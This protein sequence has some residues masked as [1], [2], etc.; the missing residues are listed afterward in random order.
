TCREP[1]LV[2]GRGDG[3]ANPHPRGAVT[4]H[5]T[6]D[7]EGTGLPSYEPDIGA[8][9]GRE[10]LLYPAGGG[11]FERWWDRTARDGIGIGDYLYRMGEIRVLVLEVEDDIPPLRHRDDERTA[12]ESVEVHA[13]IQVRQA[14]H[15]LELGGLASRVGAQPSRIYSGGVRRLSISPRRSEEQRARHEQAPHAWPRHVDE[16]SHIKSPAL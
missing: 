12:T 6:K 16:Q 8:L 3:E 9:P 10:A 11:M 7:E 13:A 2:R 14:S 4:G 1:R 5:C 15:K